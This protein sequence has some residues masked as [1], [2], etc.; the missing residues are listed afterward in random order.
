MAETL[1]EI[2]ERI[3][4]QAPQIMSGPNVH[5][6]KMKILEVLKTDTQEI[7]IDFSDVAYIDLHGLVLFRDIC[8]LVRI[9]GG[10]AYAYMLQPQMRELFEEV[11]LLA[12]TENAGSDHY[13]LKSA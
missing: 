7:I 11:D 13:L 9:A 6:L 1:A 4:A 5:K 2:K 10:K 12:E 3:T 8:D